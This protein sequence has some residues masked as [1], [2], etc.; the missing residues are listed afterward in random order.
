MGDDEWKTK[1]LKLECTLSEKAGNM[2]KVEQM[3]GGE[4]KQIE[5][6]LI[7]FDW[8]FKDKEGKM[9]LE[10]LIETDNSEIFKMR[11]I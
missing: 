8:I 2:D 7:E 11:T 4:K 5:V 6:R 1:M 9:F 10:K 3:L